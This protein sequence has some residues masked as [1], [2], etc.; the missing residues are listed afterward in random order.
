MV[1]PSTD[2]FLG[3]TAPTAAPYRLRAGLMWWLPG[4]LL[5]AGYFVF[6]YRRLAG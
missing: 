4:M 5:A 2:P 1:T 6:T 3:R